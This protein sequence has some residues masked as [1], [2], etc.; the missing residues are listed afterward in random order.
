[1]KVQ[2][3]L[4]RSTFPIYWAASSGSSQESRKMKSWKSRLLLVFTML[5]VVLVLS[6]PAMA[7]DVD[8]DV[9]CEA[10]GGYCTKQLSHEVW[11]ED[12]DEDTDAEPQEDDLDLEEPVVEETAKECFPFCEK[13]VLGGDPMDEVSDKAPVDEVSDNAPAD[14]IS[15]K[16]SS[17]QCW[18]PSGYYWPW[19]C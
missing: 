8:I 9:E 3:R 14:E 12:T 15:D 18:V 13:D 5:A 11:Q 7:E 2:K 1:M 6:V 16:D 19:P 10:D 17:E 4:L